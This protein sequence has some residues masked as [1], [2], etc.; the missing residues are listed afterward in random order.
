MSIVK[1]IE[2][3]LT[4]TLVYWGNPV[5]ISFNRYT[6]DAPVELPCRWEFVKELVKDSNGQEVVSRAR[7]WVAQDVDEMGYMYLGTMTDSE[8]NVDPFQIDSAMQIIANPK[9]PR[10]HSSTEFIRKVH[11]NMAANRTI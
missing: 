2:R 8:Y 1:F 6:F 11:L 9:V 7:V 4:Q 5:E 3:S 10:L